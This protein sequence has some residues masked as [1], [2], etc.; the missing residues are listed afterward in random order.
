MLEGWNP[1]EIIG[2]AI[3]VVLL[4]VSGIGLIVVVVDSC[5]HGHSHQWV[6]VDSK[7]MER[8]PVWGKTGDGSPVTLRLWRCE[9]GERMTDTITGWWTGEQLGQEVK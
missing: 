2:L 8:G 9:C 5:L 3:F 1:L 7:P 4:S 6:L